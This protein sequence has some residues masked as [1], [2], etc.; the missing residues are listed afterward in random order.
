MSPTFN[1]NEIDTV[2]LDMDGTLLDLAFDSYFWLQ[3]VPQSLSAQRG[4]S[5]EQAKQLITTEYRAVQHT[6]DW[7]CFDYWSER[8][9]LDIR[10][11]TSDIGPRARLRDDTAPFLAALRESGRRTILLTNAHPHSLA[12]KVTHTG[13]DQHLDLLLSTH[14]YGYPKEDQRLWHAV[15][16]HTGFNPT[17]TLFVDDSEPILD[18]AKA[19]GI[20][21]CLGVSNPDSGQQEKSFTQHPAM[22]N[23][24]S[25]L[26]AIYQSDSNH[27]QEHS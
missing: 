13:L 12:I 4:I 20:R 7:Y 9:R 24:L 18:A 22:N 27:H 8:L 23:Y 26:P 14:T 17:R 3:L 5:L 10:Q 11:M 15:Q 6:L 25:L 19:F 21:Y 2:L 1:W 16:A